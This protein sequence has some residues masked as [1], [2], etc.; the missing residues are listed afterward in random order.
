MSN[1]NRIKLDTERTFVF[2][3]TSA[4]NPAMAETIIG[5]CTTTILL[6]SGFDSAGMSSLLLKLEETQRK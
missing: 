1:D 6:K 2:G 5:N 3:L 4:G